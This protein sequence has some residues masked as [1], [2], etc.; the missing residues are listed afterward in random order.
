MGQKN[1][2]EGSGKENR[3]G[4]EGA[5]KKEERDDERGGKEERNTIYKD[6]RNTI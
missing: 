6:E 4:T 1:T 2:T 3:T 5:G